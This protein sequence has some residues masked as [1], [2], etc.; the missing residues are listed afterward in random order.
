M[1][2]AIQEGEIGPVPGTSSAEMAKMS[3]AQLNHFAKTKEKGLPVKVTKT[4][5]LHKKSF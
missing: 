4:G 2:R 1:A 3:P 5:T